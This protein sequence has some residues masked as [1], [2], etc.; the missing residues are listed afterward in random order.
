[1]K[2]PQRIAELLQR[3][4]LS[5]NIDEDRAIVWER[6]GSALSSHELDVFV[7]LLTLD[8]PEV[9]AGNR[10]KWDAIAKA[11]QRPGQ[12]RR[13]QA[14]VEEAI[15]VG[16]AERIRAAIKARRALWEGK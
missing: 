6:P 10:A 12:L 7:A 2:D 11:D 4:T 1:M 13:A 9:V 8:G 14:E 3:P 5:E 15:R 16:D